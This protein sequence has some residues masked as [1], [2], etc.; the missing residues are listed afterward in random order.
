MKLS[1]LFGVIFAAMSGMIFAQIQTSN[2][3]PNAIE[4]VA[5][6]YPW[7]AKEPGYWKNANQGEVYVEITVNTEG[8]VTAARATGLDKVFCELAESAALKWKFEKQEQIKTSELVFS[9]SRR[10]VSGDSFK[11]ST[12]FKFPNRLEVYIEVG[13]I[14]RVI[15]TD[16]EFDL[17]VREYGVDYMAVRYCDLVQNPQKHDGKNVAV[18]ATYRYGRGWQELFGMKCRDRG[19]TWVEFVSE[20]D[21]KIN[22]FLRKTPRDQGTL[23]ATFYGKFNSTDVPYGDSGY[24]F[25]IVVELVKDI[26]IVSK[27][28]GEPNRLSN[29]K[30][31][32]ICHG[33]EE[34]SLR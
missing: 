10:P 17:Y 16:P 1:F 25:K 3:F 6:D 30:Q 14:E 33:D 8:L 23:N 28:G 31:K 22:R 27:N 9:F 5:P 18:H 15:F 26:K 7:I 32:K 21:E 2:Q 12:A 4:V 24:V 19:K 29:K 13:E 20:N 11:I 34:I